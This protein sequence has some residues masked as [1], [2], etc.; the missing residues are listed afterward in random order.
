ML[1]HGRACVAAELAHGSA[2]MAAQVAHGG[3]PHHGYHRAYMGE[4]HPIAGSKDF[5]RSRRGVRGEKD[6]HS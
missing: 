6:L 4:W 2:C 5:G 3:V 1:A